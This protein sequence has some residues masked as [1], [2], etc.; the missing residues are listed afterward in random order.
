MRTDRQVLQ[1]PD[2]RPGADSDGPSLIALIERCWSDYPGVILHVDAEAPEL[3]ALASYYSRLGGALWVAGHADGM[4]GTK[5]LGDGVWEIGRVYVHP[6]LHG[7][8]LANR[9]M[10]VAEA[11]GAPQRLML[12][13]DTQFTRAHRFY[14]KRGYVRTARRSV[15]DPISAFDEWKFE[16]AVPIDNDQR[17]VHPAS[18]RPIPR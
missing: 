8:G 12:W 18:D 4:I 14:E 17:A 9:L 16:R 5:P 3:R 6:N 15:Q 2:I 11:F 1:Q 10:D 13:S 7:S